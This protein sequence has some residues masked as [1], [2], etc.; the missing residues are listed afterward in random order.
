MSLRIYFL[1]A[2]RQALA[3]CRFLEQVEWVLIR[4]AEGEYAGGE[5]Q[6]RSIFQYNVSLAIY[7][8]V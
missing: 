7:F 6:R 4:P 8:K 2:K 3:R 1:Y 5:L